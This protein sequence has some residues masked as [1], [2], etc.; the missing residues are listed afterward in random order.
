MA[1]A[2]RLRICAALLLAAAHIHAQLTATIPTGRALAL[3][4]GQHALLFKPAPRGSESS[5]TC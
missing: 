4:T 1:A 3:G 2:A 5:R